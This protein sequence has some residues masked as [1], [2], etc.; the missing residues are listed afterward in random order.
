MLE[1][2]AL[3][4]ALSNK[5]YI[6]KKSNELVNRGEHS[7]LETFDNGAKGCRKEEKE[8][9]EEREAKQLQFS[10]LMERYV[11]TNPVN[12]LTHHVPESSLNAY[13]SYFLQVRWR[14]AIT[15][16]L[17]LRHFLQTLALSTLGPL[18]IKREP[19][20]KKFYQA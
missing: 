8:E 2:F 5:T 10:R 11:S 18:T 19:S 6:D 20:L 9:K 14:K 1:L 12:L 7:S 17:D 15:P 13:I 3:S 16:V 4:V